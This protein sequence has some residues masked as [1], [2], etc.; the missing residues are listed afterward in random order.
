M[1]HGGSDSGP[2][3][4]HDFSTNANPLPVP[5][6]LSAA[7]QAADRCRY[8]DPHYLALREQL[9]R[10]HGVSPERILPASGGAEAIR[11][12][13]LAALL[14]GLR[15]VW[16]PSP[17]FGDYAAAA[18]A[19]GLRVR[20]YADVTQLLQELGSEAMVWICEPCNPTGESLASAQIAAV[21]ARAALTVLDRA[22]EPLRL[23]GTAPAL[24]SNCWTLHCPNKALGHTGV[25][26]AYLI[27]AEDYAFSHRVQQLAASWVLSAEGQV[28]LMQLHRPEIQAWLAD[29]RAQLRR[30]SVQQREMLASLGW[31]QRES[32]TPF[33]LARPAVPLDHEDLRAHGIKLRDASSFGLPGWV[34]VA[35]LP[36]QSQLALKKVI[37]Q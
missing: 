36:P 15:E 21:A 23:A 2:P 16:V 27:A 34:R 11:R 26:A 12:L 32:C 1:T 29:S 6:S 14:Q 13:S 10:A 4:L 19:L 18:Q 31:Q 30:W 25:R 24:P 37:A 28:L 7:L 3:L 17:G 35:T 33:W 20:S 5:A 8:P 22:Y 9:G